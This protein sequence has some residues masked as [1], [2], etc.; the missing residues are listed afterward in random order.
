[1][2]KEASSGSAKS[3]PI[4]NPSSPKSSLISLNM[5]NITKL[6]PTNFITWRLQVRALLE[7][8]ELH[9][10]I[11]DDPYIP[12]ETVKPSDGPAVPN[13]EFAAW[14]RQDKMLYSS[15]P[16]SLSLAVQP[17]VARATTSREVWEILHRTYGKPSRG[18]IKQLKQEIKHLTK[19]NKSINEY[20]RII[21]DRTDQLALLGAAMEH[22]DLLDVIISGLD[23][24]YRAIL[25][26]VNGRDVPISIDEL[27]EKLINRENTLHSEEVVPNSAPVT[28][29]NAQFRSQQGHG[30]FSGNRG[31]YYNSHGGYSPSRGGFR[32]PRPYLG[33]CQICG[34]QGHDAKQCPEYQQGISTSHH[35]QYSPHQA[36]PYHGLLPWP[37]SAPHLPLSSP[38]WSNQAHHTTATSPDLYPWLLDSGASHHIASDLSSLSLHSPYTGGESVTVGN[39]AA[40]PIT[41][42]GSTIL[43]STSLSLY[44]NNVLCVPS[45][46]KNLISVNKLCKANNVMV[47]LCPFDFQV[48][49]LKTGIILLSGKANEGVYEWPLKHTPPIYVF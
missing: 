4:F 22:E 26:M 33:K 17:I 37:A 48:K 21:V 15:L 31:G 42:T 6:T 25:E 38:Q 13:P 29:H 43:P 47:Q 36:S 10:F 9:W 20:M 32:P 44:L 40:L 7:A 28:T 23:D 11:A 27:H 30:S 5:S 18:H 24:D 41:H 45:I 8:H 3:A 39:G 16:C 46:H 1:M 12:E 14:Q 35:Q 19:D 2:A 34:V 49:D